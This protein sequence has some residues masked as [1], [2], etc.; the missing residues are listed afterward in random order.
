MLCQENN[1]IYN[2][3]QNPQFCLKGWFDTQMGARLVACN[4]GDRCGMPVQK[5]KE[6]ESQLAK[7]S[8][9][10]SKITVEQLHGLMSQ[11]IKDTLF[12]SVMSS[13]TTPG[14]M[15]AE[16]STSTTDSSGPEPMVEA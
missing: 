12:N 4:P 10:S 13:A 2:G 8:R 5:K 9:D 6:E 1:T 16:T 15:S 3:H 11:V 14:A 7:I